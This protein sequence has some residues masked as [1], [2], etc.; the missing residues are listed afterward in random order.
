LGD[1]LDALKDDGLVRDIKHVKVWTL[2]S[3]KFVATLTVIMSKH[4][5]NQE[6]QSVKSIVRQAFKRIHVD[7]VS[8]EI[9]FDN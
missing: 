3:S 2:C 1:V 7:N 8:I 9:D 4:S 5:T 6:Q